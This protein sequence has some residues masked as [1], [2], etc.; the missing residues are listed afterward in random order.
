VY[1]ITLLQQ[2]CLGYFLAVLQSP[3]VH[4]HM[5]EH[6]ILCNLAMFVLLVML[7]LAIQRLLKHAL[8]KDSW[9]L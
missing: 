7:L 2:C 5:L 3:N 4:T 1:S 8:T 6:W 9:L